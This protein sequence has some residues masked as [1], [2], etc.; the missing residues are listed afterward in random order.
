M[1]VTVYQ[2]LAIVRLRPGPRVVPEH[3]QIDA[4]AEFEMLF[5]ML[6]VLH[7]PSV[8]NA[9][10]LARPCQLWPVRRTAGTLDREQPAPD[11]LP[12]I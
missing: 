2:I 5:E 8:S 9:G 3:P 1:L 12:S 7:D 4:L 11:S 6:V 10:D